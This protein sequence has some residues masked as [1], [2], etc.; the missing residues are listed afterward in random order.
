MAN[1]TRMK[2][3]YCYRIFVGLP[4]D[5]DE[6]RML[7]IYDRVSA[8]FPDGATVTPGSGIWEGGVENSLVITVL[9]ENRVDK[10]VLDLA[11][12]LKSLLD[13]DVVMVT[14]TEVLDCFFVG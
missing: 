14:A 9:Q 6:R 13:Q 5:I 7:I 3:P 1:I 4:T 10:P 8:H 11:E 12:V 2:N